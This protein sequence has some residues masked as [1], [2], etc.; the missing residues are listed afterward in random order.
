MCSGFY[1]R[2]FKKI[3]INYDFIQT[4]FE[5]GKKTESDIF[6]TMYETLTHEVYHGISKQG[7][8]L[9]LTESSRREIY[10]IALNEIFNENAADRTVYTARNEE[11]KLKRKT[12]GYSEITFLVDLLSASLGIDDKIMLKSGIQ[13]R[14]KLYNVLKRNYSEYDFNKNIL[15]KFQG[16]ETNLDM[17]YNCIYGDT[18]DPCL[19]FYSNSLYEN[20]YSLASNNLKCN[21]TELDSQYVQTIVKSY[22]NLDFLI[23]E[24]LEQFISKKCISPQSAKNIKE[25]LKDLKI[26]YLKQVTDII[27][28]V[29]IKSQIQDEEFELYAKDFAKHGELSKESDIIKSVFGVEI[30]DDDIEKRKTCIEN[31][32]QKYKNQEYSENEWDNKEIIKQMKKIYNDKTMEIQQKENKLIYR[33]FRKIKNSRGQKF[34]QYTQNDE[35]YK[36]NKKIFDEKYKVDI[37]NIK[38]ISNVNQKNVEKTK[39]EPKNDVEKM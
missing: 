19:K 11:E 12:N 27:K 18:I 31:E 9:G 16:I 39:N 5:R 23:N 14:E 17:I 37:K 2:S 7:K 25:N 36:E 21:N 26:D 15:S 33:F 4:C 3:N 30:I 22:H 32:I 6:T 35:I 13:N 28:F 1:Y 10:G 20:I 38:E 24:S 34:L 8:I 29:K